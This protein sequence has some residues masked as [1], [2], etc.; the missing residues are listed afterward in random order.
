M[1]YRQLNLDESNKIRE[2]DGECYVNKAWRKIGGTRQLIV[3]DWTDH[4]LPNGLSWHIEHFEKSQIE[5]GKA[6]GCFDNDTLIGYSVVNANLFGSSKEYVL[7]D[8]I[9]ISKNYRG[10][11]IGKELFQFSCELARQMKARKLY[12]CAGSSEDTVAFYFKLGCKEATEVNQDLYEMDSN[13]LQL[14]YVL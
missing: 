2:I 13:D 8:Q 4:E 12:I 6:V 1:L 14:E 10:K 11:G 5:G 9:F 3:I 7:L